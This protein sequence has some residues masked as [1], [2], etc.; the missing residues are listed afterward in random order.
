MIQIDKMIS[1][2]DRL[3]GKR[4]RQYAYIYKI[5]FVLCL[6]IFLCCV[7]MHELIHSIKSLAKALNVA[8]YDRSVD[9]SKDI[10]CWCTTGLRQESQDIGCWCSTA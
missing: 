4:K 2:D 1:S 3:N 8:N 7:L 9:L 10:D 6:N 5:I